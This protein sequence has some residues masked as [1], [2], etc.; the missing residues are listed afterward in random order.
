MRF[1]IGIWDWNTKSVSLMWRRRS[2]HWWTSFMHIVLR[3]AMVGTS[4]RPPSEPLQSTFVLYLSQNQPRPVQWSKTNS[5]WYVLT[6]I[7]SDHT[8][9]WM[10]V[11]Q[12]HISTDRQLSWQTIRGPLGQCTWCKHS[13]ADGWTGMEWV[14]WEFASMSSVSDQFDTHYVG[15]GCQVKDNDTL[16]ECRVGVVRSLSRHLAECESQRCSCICRW[17]CCCTCYYLLLP[18]ICCL[19]LLLLLPFLAFSCHLMLKWTWKPT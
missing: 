9:I 14:S 4:L 10:I 8:L 2:G 18:S 5:K 16:Q 13:G 3:L 17:P 12:D 7:W 15:T 19:H 6:L 11:V 1:Q